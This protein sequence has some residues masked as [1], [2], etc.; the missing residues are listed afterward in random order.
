[1]TIPIVLGIAAALLLLGV[2]FLAVRVG[3]AAHLRLELQ[4]KLT[5]QERE[6]KKLQ[7][8][9]D[10]QAGK[11]AKKAQEASKKQSKA[12][13]KQQRIGQLTEELQSAKADAA[14]NEEKVREMTRSLAVVRTEREAMRQKL[15]A[16]EARLSETAAVEAE[17]ETAEGAAPVVEEAS[18]EAATEARPDRPGEEV[19]KLKAALTAAERDLER[20][21]RQRDK[22]EQTARRFK[23][24]LVEREAA[25]REL[26]RKNE[27]NR[28]AYIITQ[29]QLDVLQ[30]ENYRLIHGH[31]PEFKQADKRTR[32]E[33]LKPAVEVVRPNFDS[34]PIDLTG[35]PFD[36]EEEAD[37]LGG[38]VPEGLDT[39]AGADLEPTDGD[40]DGLELRG[41][42]DVADEPG[43]TSDG[44]DT[45]I[46]GDAEAAGADEPGE[47]RPHTVRLRKSLKP[48]DEPESPVIPAGDRPAAPPR[49]EAPPRPVAPPRPTFGD[50][51]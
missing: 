2:I 17:T 12:Q 8:N 43:V 13:G 14:Q 9:L 49:P 50:D 30:D 3:E 28:R 36:E 20:V 29:L 25:V 51:R 45:P 48:E 24:Q 23:R 46:S 39:G 18:S 7:A 42:A 5:E 31:E 37:D 40:G 6:N 27:N 22:L 21:D 44:D 33:A 16:L 26:R 38:G 15:R 34:A 1:M 10:A 19:R 47:A 4:S 35:V 41:L 11:Y 32:R